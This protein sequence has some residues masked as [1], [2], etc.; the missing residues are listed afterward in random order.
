MTPEEFD[1]QVREQAIVKAV[2]DREI[3]ATNVITE[4]QARKYYTD[5]PSLFEQPEMAHVAH[6]VIS[7][8]DPITGKELIPEVKLEKKRLAEKILAQARAGEDFGKLVKQY[9]QDPATKDRGG[10]YTFPRAKDN[11]RQA[12]VPEFEAAAFSMK[13]NQISDVVETS[14]GYHVIKLLELIPAK[15]IDYLQVQ[16]RIKENLLREQVEKALPAF[17]EKLRT[18]AGVKIM[19]SRYMERGTSQ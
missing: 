4:A 12:M 7:T 10:E 17:V 5:N 15:K 8:H 2:I 1:K 6:I 18:E 16:D 13:P 3:K 9:S 19:A 11:P 14:Y